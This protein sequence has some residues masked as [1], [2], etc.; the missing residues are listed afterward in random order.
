MNKK[1]FVCEK[2]S[3]ARDI[4]RALG[5]TRKRENYIEGSEVLVTWCLGH[6]LEAAKPD[7][8]CA[9]LKPW[10]IEK[11]PILPEQWHMEPVNKVKK[12]FMA[13]KKLIKS[14]S[15]I[16]IAT[17]ADREGELIARELIAYC[18]YQGK[19]ERLWLS[20]LDDAS[21]K[22]ALKAIKPGAETENLYFAGLS[23]QRADWIVGMNMTMA[24]SCLF[25]KFGEGVLSV[26]RVQTPTLQLIVAR[27]RAIEQFQPKDYFEL[28]VN[29]ADENNASVWLKWNIPE[30]LQ[31]DDSGRCLDKEAVNNVASKIRGKSAKITSLEKLKKKQ[32]PPLPYSLSELQKKAS[33]LYGFTAAKTLSVAQELYEKHKAITYPRTD[34]G[35]LPLS[36]HAESKEVL[37]ALLKIDSSLS[38]LINLCDISFKSV[39]WNDKK[40]TAH[41]GIIPTSSESVKLTSMSVEAKKLYHLIRVLYI[42]QFL[43]DFKYEQTKI[44][45]ICEEELFSATGRVPLV[46][47]W[48]KIFEQ[49]SG[50]DSMEEDGANQ[51]FPKWQEGQT[52]H[53]ENEK[54]MS[55]KTKPPASFTE[56]TLISAMESIG[57]YVEDPALKKILRETSGIGTQATRAAII[58]TLIRR[59]YITRDK[60]KL[61]SMEKGR[62]LID[63]L[64]NVVKDPATTARWEQDLD[65]MAAG[66]LNQ[67]LFIANQKKNL[68]EMLDALIN[69][70]ARQ[71]P[72]I[73][74][75]KAIPS[76]HKCPDCQK[77]MVHRKQKAKNSYF[78][79]CS[80]YP[81]CRTTLPDINGKPGKKKVAAKQTNQQCTR[82]DTG[83]FVERK[84]TRG[85]FYGCSNYPKCKNIVQNIAVS[86]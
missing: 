83:Y 35:Y 46:T 38:N 47:G 77:P 76:E 44:S 84:S 37:G 51:V 65:D 11:L 73:Q 55:K 36:Q 64:P 70:Y 4:A 56:G 9:N 68:S 7:Y 66:S 45:V 61:I 63:L 1:L 24:T 69:G 39:A 57:R 60:K 3:Q 16:V 78:W 28:F 82:C 67:E 33:A 22:K 42:A 23:R 48:K 34:S 54:V 2:P 14:S 21:I 27:D 40:V 75:R 15:H 74:N 10:R 59:N 25:G 62:A 13:V 86:Q 52:L 19:I 58:E 6:L 41:H 43:G 32:A 71:S 12:Q 80:G 49:S 5:A 30:V 72:S 18:H 53:V 29:F 17:D 8:Y 50:N 26:G 31:Q 20:A 85:K 79:G 81:E